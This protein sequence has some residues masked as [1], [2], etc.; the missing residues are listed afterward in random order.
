MKKLGL[1]TVTAVLLAGNLF[2]ESTTLEDAF[3]NGKVNGEL[4]VYGIYSDNKG[5][6]LDSGYSLGSIS[7]G[8]ETDTLNGFKATVGFMANS[9]LSEK[10]NGDYSSIDEPKSIMNIANVS[11]INDDYT[12]IAGR[13]MI[14]LEWIADYH[15][16]VVGVISNIPNTT[17]ILGHTDKINTS[18]NDGALERFSKFN[19]S[20]GAS[21][22]DV[23]Y[24]MDDSL[25]FG[26]YYM[27]ARNLFNAFGGKAELSILEFAVSAKYAVT[28]EDRRNTTTNGVDGDIFAVDISY[29]NDLFGLNTGYIT[30]DKTG[31][32]GSLATLG[33]NIN[34]FDT[35]NQVYGT[36]ADTYYIGMNG[37]LRGFNLGIL[38]G[39]TDYDNSGIEETE[40]EFNFTIEKEVYKNTTLNLLFADINAETSNND[41]TYYTAQLVYSF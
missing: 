26:A 15:E 19:G 30:T 41:S 14:D 31:A 4:S 37:N 40:K 29:S 17:I 34:P 9:E 24:K 39:S 18:A 8:Y 20:K 35:G 23:T 36:D 2:A 27:N 5:T 10:E 6:T 16:A 32:I 25:T 3:K 7:M 11:Y 28:N 33:D 21:V 12:I 13:Q 38:Y 22:V 1:S